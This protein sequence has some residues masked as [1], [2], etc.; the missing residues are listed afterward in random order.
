VFE[1]KSKSS[2]TSARVCISGQAKQLLLLHGAARIASGATD[3]HKLLDLD[4]KSFAVAWRK[5]R[6]KSKRC[7]QVNHTRYRTYIETMVSTFSDTL[8]Q[9]CI[10]CKSHKRGE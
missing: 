2:V 9:H 4:D 7:L 3:D 6:Q 10:S 1:H 5:V 8:Y